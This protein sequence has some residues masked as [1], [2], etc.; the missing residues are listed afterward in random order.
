MS[1]TSDTN[2]V[3]LS[4]FKRTVGNPEFFSVTLVGQLKRVKKLEFIES[5]IPYVWYD[6]NAGNCN[7]CNINGSDVIIPEGQYTTLASIRTAIIA[8][9]PGANVTFVGTS[10]NRYSR[11]SIDNC[12]INKAVNVGAATLGFEHNM[13]VGTQVSKI[14]LPSKD[15][16]YVF[17]AANNTLTITFDG[18]DRVATITPGN[19]TYYDL[20]QALQTAIIALPNISTATVTYS[21][22]TSSYTLSITTIA[23]I[24][25]TTIQTSNLSRYLGIPTV[26]TDSIGSNPKVFITNPSYPLK[27]MIQIR[28]YAINDLLSI[29]ISA[30]QIS[31]QIGIHRIPVKVRPSDYIND[32]SEYRQPIYLIRP[33][34]LQTL[35]LAI[36]DEDGQVLNLNGF[37]WSVSMLIE[38]E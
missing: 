14:P 3:V 18:I 22:I 1:V 26:L 27:K 35:D 15:A 34:I 31:S 32:E 8:A 12:Y 2:L 5:T 21:R 16:Y 36:L 28:S 10:D 24:T 25:T 20:C 4:S 13:S 30:S 9:S 19:Y 11:I 7:I 37:D 17:K 29:A 38:T 33:Q 6:I 23:P